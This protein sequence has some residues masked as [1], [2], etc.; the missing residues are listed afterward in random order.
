MYKPDELPLRRRT[1]MKLAAVPTNRL[2]WTLE[3]CTDVTPDNMATVQ[4]W[5]A[6]AKSGNIIRAVGNKSCGLGLALY[7]APGQ[8]KTA[9]ALA[10]LQDVL[11]TFSLEDFDVKEGNS[12]ARP[13]YFIQY[14]S[15]VELRGALMDSPTNDQTRLWEGILGD[16]KEDTYNIRVLVID[17]LGK[18]HNSG[19]GWQSSLLHHVLRT[20]FNNGLPTILTTNLRKWDTTY[21]EATES[22][23]HEAFVI[24][25]LQSSIG[26]LRK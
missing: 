10:A 26:D 12:M 13:G 23:M 7:G 9:L 6:R 22:F 15:L 25:E 1:W 4:K 20:R 19:T 24:V 16:C 2:G 17:D 14:S 5:I 11:R 3:D 21:G 8:G 18:E